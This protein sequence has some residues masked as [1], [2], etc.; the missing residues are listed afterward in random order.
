M[1]PPTEGRFTDMTL[2]SYNQ[3]SSRKFVQKN[4]KKKVN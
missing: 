4:N 2:L 3:K 1:G